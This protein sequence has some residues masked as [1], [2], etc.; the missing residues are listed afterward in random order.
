MYD[1]LIGLVILAIGY[2]V[3]GIIF[4]VRALVAKEDS[5]KTRKETESRFIPDPKAKSI[6][7]RAVELFNEGELVQAERLFQDAIRIQPDFQGVLLNSLLTFMGNDWGRAITTL[8]MVLRIDPDYSYGKT[9]LAA[10]L[11]NRGVEL[12]QNGD[13]IEALEYFYSA[14]GMDVGE[15][16]EVQARKNISASFTAMGVDAYKIKNFKAAFMFIR[17]ALIAMPTNTTKDNF[18][19]AFASLAREAMTA[20][21]FESAVDAFERAEDLGYIPFENLNDYGVSLV[22]LGRIEEAIRAFERALQ[23][24]PDNEKV[25]FNL[26]KLKEMRQDASPDMKPMEVEANFEAITSIPMNW[27]RAPE[28]Q[29]YELR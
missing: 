1:L 2:G 15:E 6:F 9:N 28:A 27:R 19:R 29:T 14:L 22:F 18:G 12:A 25:Q 21:E 4:A 26:T 23:M 16:I 5:A 20:E 8:R 11:L 7:E 17:E 3:I 24:N 13:Q 10:A